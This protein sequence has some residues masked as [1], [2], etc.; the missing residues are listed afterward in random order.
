MHGAYVR[1]QTYMYACIVM[2]IHMT[3]ISCYEVFVL[4]KFY[5]CWT[6]CK[7]PVVYSCLKVL[8]LFPSS[9]QA[10][11]QR[12]IIGFPTLIPVLRY[13]AE[14]PFHPAQTHT[15]K[16]IQNCVSDCPGIASTSNIEELAL[17]L[18]RM[19]ERHGD[20]EI[21]MIPETFLL[22]CSIF[23]VLLKFPSSHM[24]SNLATL[25]QESL[26]HAVLACLAISEK[27]QGQLLHSLYLLK[28]AYSYSHEEFFANKSSNFQ[29]RTCIVDLCTSHIL[30]WF[31]SAINEINEEAVLGVLETFHFILLQYPD[32]QATKLA[33][34]LLLSSWLSFSFGCLGLFPTEKMKW[35]V[36][37]MLSSLVDVLLG[38]QAGQPIRDVTFFLPSDPIDL[39][40]LLGQKSSHNLDL[41]SSQAAVLMLLHVSCLHDDW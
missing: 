23:V 21:G 3:S 30:P 31:A 18:S 28:E 24:A 13:V 8:N 40:F 14:V 9:E 6:E 17:I 32:T 19:L 36:Y 38:N 41:S 33:K 29:L 10:F 12:L 7:D 2:Y 26:K 39:L 5:S 16:L 4:M 1:T 27:D 15:L 34:A 22:V 11:R 20:G 37:L 35:R 25:L